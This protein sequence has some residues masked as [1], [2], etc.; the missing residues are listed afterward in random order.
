MATSYLHKVKGL[1]ELAALIGPRPRTRTVIMCH[2]TF[3]IVHPGH[4]RH[5]TYAR[6][7]A[8]ILI[9]SLTADVHILKADHRPYVPQ[10]LRA[11]N[12]AALEMVDYVIVDPN[13]TP[14]EHIK[15]L[16]PD[17]F[18]KGYEYFSAGI[19]PRTQEEIATLESYGGEMVFTPGDI[20]YSSSKLIDA[21]PPKITIEKLLALMESEG[22]G[23]ADLRKTLASLSGAN[24]HVLGD[25][26]VDVYSSCTLLGGAPKSP[27][28]SVKLER[29]ET[30]TGGAGIVARHVKAAG[31]RVSLG[32]VLG[33]D[34][35][36]TFALAELEE[37]GVECAAIVDRTR[38]TT[39]KERFIADGHKMLQVDRA[40][41]RPIS[42]RIL[43]ALCEGLA[44]SAADVVIF[45]DFRHGIFNRQ[46]IGTLKDHLPASALRVADSQV[47]NRWGNI[48]DFTDFDLLTPNEREARFALAD[49]DSVVRPLASE[50]FRQARCRNLIL[51]LGDRG[52]IGYR[53]PGPMPR[54]F[55]TIDSFVTSLVDPIGAGDALVAYASLTLAVTGNIVLASILGSM[56]AAVTCERQ[57]NVPVAPL[58]VESKIDV[59]ERLSRYR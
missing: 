32:T 4:L 55:F 57:G 48:L 35:A 42:G 33:D 51:K 36:R 38:P 54:E 8:D 24:V 2:G 43:R 18:A 26:I 21:H 59:V 39:Q 10:E 46:T 14:I 34:A 28:F 3:D 27:T 40:D 17:Y 45:S 44:G 50:L 16:Q 58:E 13:P 31:A 47:S 20:V 52:I 56:A 15:V 7:K 41:N 6:D 25:T 19:P 53:S 29:S 12:L 22:I 30:F 1:D 37:A 5:L 11:S 9:A 23:F 49:Q